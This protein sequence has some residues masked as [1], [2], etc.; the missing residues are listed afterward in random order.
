MWTRWGAAL[1]QWWAAGL[2]HC[3]SSSGVA[4]TSSGQTHCG[5]MHASAT[6]RISCRCTHVLVSHTL[7]SLSAEPV[8]NSPVSTG[9]H[10]THVTC[11]TNTQRQTHCHEPHR[12]DTAV[13]LQCVVPCQFCT[14]TAST[15]RHH[16]C[17]VSCGCNNCKG[18]GWCVG[19]KSQLAGI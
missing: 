1:W 3:I 8:T 13:C 15:E 14:H 4:C 18:W 12:E 11:S 2:V 7:T 16:Q 5:I 10:T 6:D 17:S 19:S 9:Y